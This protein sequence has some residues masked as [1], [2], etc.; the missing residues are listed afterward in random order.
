M[1]AAITCIGVM[2]TS[3]VSPVLPDLID[4]L[5]V[6]TGAAG[7][8][9]AAGAVPGIFMAPIIGVLADKWGRRRILVPCLALF[10]IAGLASALAPNLAVL[11]ACRVL[12]GIGAAGLVNLVVVLIG[13]HWT[14]R[15]RATTLGRNS[16]VLTVAVA[17]WPV[18]GGVLAELGGW[19]WAF[20]PYSLGLLVAVLAAVT[21]PEE[22]PRTSEETIGSR[23]GG[24]L[25]GLTRGDLAVP[26]LAGVAVFAVYF[27]VNLTIVPVHLEERFGLGPGLR[28]VVFAV[29]AIASVTMALNLGRI[30]AWLDRSGTVRVGFVVFILS[31]VA[32]AAS[33]AVGLVFL[34]VVPLGLADGALIP[35]L[36]DV[37]TGRA[38]DENRGAVT[39]TYVSGVR[40]G[41]TIG[42]LGAGVALGLTTST[43]ALYLVAGL[44]VFVTAALWPGLATFR[45]TDEERAGA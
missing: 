19:R 23:L 40:A 43:G 45:A 16:A 33:P 37:V 41:Q 22:P 11:L 12:Q 1:L 14:G 42:P 10:G 17:F 27:A 30:H 34:A 13:D 28:G 44:T 26:V 29:P 4:D 8:I 32:I 38:D 15:E 6:S 21:L 7:L 5:E 39:A 9:I 36:Q 18:L 25:T 24:V 2:S 31:T 20:A 3:L 35:T